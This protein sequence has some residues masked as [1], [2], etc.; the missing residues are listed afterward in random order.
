[1]ST[2][3]N[4]TAF[5]ASYLAIWNETDSSN[6]R[7]MIEQA[8]TEE[9]TYVDPVAEVTGRDALSALIAAVQAQFPGHRFE[10]HTEPDAHHDRVRFRWALTSDDGA[11]VAIGLDI[12]ELDGD[13]RARAVTGFL[14]P[15]Q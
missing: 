4:E 3:T 6:R 8:M 15:V 2:A 11:P 5:V 9:V 13:G 10:L 7:E 14:D 12:A 1:M